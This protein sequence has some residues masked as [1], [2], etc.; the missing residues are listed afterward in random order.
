MGAGSLGVDAWAAIRMLM[1]SWGISMTAELEYWK[2]ALAGPA[3]R[4]VPIIPF[5]PP[6]APA[7][8]QNPRSRVRRESKAYLPT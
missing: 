8:N 2:A 1:K 4:R 7:A 6:A 5:V 3:G